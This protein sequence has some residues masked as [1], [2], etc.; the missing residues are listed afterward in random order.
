[1]ANTND[2]IRVWDLPVRLFHWALVLL[3][4]LAVL[5]AV[6]ADPLARLLDPGKPAAEVAAAG[7]LLRIFAPQL[8]LYGIGIV[9]TGV[10]QAY[11]RFAWP[12]LAPLMSSVTVVSTGTTSC[13][14]ETAPFGY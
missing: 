7:R 2:R 4:P 9:L 8:P 3:V 11:R 12:V 10:L 14:K 6:L 5:V 13:W 1:M